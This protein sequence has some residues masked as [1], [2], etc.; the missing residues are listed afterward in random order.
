[1]VE[2][3][4]NFFASPTR[5]AALGVAAGVLVAAVIVVVQKVRSK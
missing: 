2:W 4:E 5:S 3:F 1:M